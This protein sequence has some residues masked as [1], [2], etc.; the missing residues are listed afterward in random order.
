[1]R[2][3]LRLP[4][5]GKGRELRGGGAVNDLVVD[6]GVLVDENVAESLHL[7]QRVSHVR[8]DDAG[9]CELLAEVVLLGRKRHRQLDTALIEALGGRG[10]AQVVPE[11]R[12]RLPD[13]PAAP[14]LDSEQARFRLYDSFAALLLRAAAERPIV[15]L[16]D[17][18]HWAD[19]AS[20]LLLHFVAREITEARLLVVATYRDVEVSADHP[21]GELLPALRRERTVDRVLLRGLPDGAVH[22]LL[23]GIRGADVPETFTSSL[24]RETSGNP[25]FIREILRHLLDEGVAYRVGDRWETRLDEKDIRLPES[26]R[27]VI[28]RRLARLGDPTRMLLR[29][30]SVVGREFHLDVLERVGDRAADQVLDAIEEAG[31]IRVVEAVPETIG[32]YRFSHALVRETL[33]GELR[34]V[35]RL[36][37]HRRIGEALEKIFARDPERH[38]ASWRITSWGRYRA[39]LPARPSTTQPA[40][41]IAPARSSRTRRRRFSTDA[42]LRR[43]TSPT[44]PTSGCAASC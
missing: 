31:A 15:L 21:L 9:I 17:D 29:L 2:Q 18:L 27:E 37:L 16:L 3:K 26:I 10:V 38:L 39:A 40:P 19:K 35:D 4:E 41:A 6:A 30:A 14:P 44:H 12:E 1:M 8:G 24:A 43:S 20:L 36:R 5:G 23:V 28:G 22:T 42:R 7:L 34:T 33:Y 25:F 11:V 13:V 32:R